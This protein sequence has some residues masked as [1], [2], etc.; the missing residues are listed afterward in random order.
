MQVYR[1]KLTIIKS[2]ITDFFCS[3]VRG[4]RPLRGFGSVGFE[5]RLLRVSGLAVRKSHFKCLYSLRSD[6]CV[7]A[8]ASQQS[9]SGKSARAGKNDY[10]SVLR[11]TAANL[12]A[13]TAGLLKGQPLA[14]RV[15]HNFTL[16][17]PPGRGTRK[18]DCCRTSPSSPNRSRD[19]DRCCYCWPMQTNSNRNFQRC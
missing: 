11:C 8:V 17:R 16:R 9:W 7:P 18:T 2:P 6:S 15:T 13:R 12:P 4:G 1:G 5:I 14:G 19:F 3:F 10:F